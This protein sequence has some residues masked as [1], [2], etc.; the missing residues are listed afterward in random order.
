MCGK[1]IGVAPDATL[2]YFAVPDDN[3][4]PYNYCLALEKLISIND[5]LPESKKIRIVSISDD[6]YKKDKEAYNKWIVLAEKAEERNIAIVYSSLAIEH[7]TWGGCPDYLDKDSPDNYD[8]NSWVRNK[9]F[10]DFKK[11]IILPADNRTVAKNKT[12]SSYF[13]KGKGG[14][15]S[16]IPYFAGLSALAWQVNPDLDLEDIYKYV[17]ESKTIRGDSSYVVN[18][19]ELIK[20]VRTNIK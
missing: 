9:N 14:F 17:D 7:F 11:M 13:H 10:R 1:T 5:T 2:F 8:Y 4:K 19:V 20:L 15:S 6:I 12:N 16:A 3:N 18:P